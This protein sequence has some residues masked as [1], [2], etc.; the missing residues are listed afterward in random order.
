M[1]DS[2]RRRG[3]AESPK[4]LPA[5]EQR[6]FP[7]GDAALEA[8]A[9]EVA[10]AHNEEASGALARREPGGGGEFDRRV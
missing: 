1:P 2:E 9:L 8:S 3:S 6:R 7:K 5:E 10:Q 4:T